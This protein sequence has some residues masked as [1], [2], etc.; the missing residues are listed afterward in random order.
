MGRSGFADDVTML[1]AQVLSDPAPELYLEVPAQVGSV[2]RVRRAF[3]RWLCEID[4]TAI[5]GNDLLL[6]VAETITN[7]VEHAYPADR[8]G[9]VQFRAVFLAEGIVECQV[10]DHGRWRPPDPAVGHRGHGLMVAGQVVD[11]MRVSHAMPPSGAGPGSRGTVVTLRH[12]LRRPVTIT[13]DTRGG[14][15]QAGSGVAFSIDIDSDGPVP[16]A[17]VRGPVDGSTAERLSRQLLTAC[18]GGTLPITLD[19]TGIT[20]LASSGVRAI[21]QVKER[22]V[23]HQQDLTILAAAGSSAQDLLELARLPHISR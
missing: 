6:A 7:A 17:R 8:P 13:A 22:L 20:Y 10:T 18:R 23:E 19:L 3:A 5:D 11:Y 4:P 14:A 1:A 15:G 21:Y 12:R 9:V 2:L 16:R